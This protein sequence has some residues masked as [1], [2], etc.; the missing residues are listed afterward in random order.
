M[1]KY[2]SSIKKGNLVHALEKIK[3]TKKI[4]NKKIVI[5]VCDSNEFMFKSILN[6]ID[7]I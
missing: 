4:D 5:V 3:V 6:E 1:D 2:L 7:Y